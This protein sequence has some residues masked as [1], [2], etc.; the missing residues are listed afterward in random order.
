MKRTLM[1]VLF[2]VV[3]GVVF[4]QSK[5]A[6]T[7]K[8]YLAGM[9]CENCVAKVETALKAVDGVSSV[10]VSLKQSVANVTLASAIQTDALMKAV[11]D[12]GYTASLTKIDAKTKK[13]VQQHEGEHKKGEEKCD[14][15]CCEKEKKETV[16]S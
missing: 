8:L 16:K 5:K 4:G 7:V 9:H 2:L 6:S 13:E 14:G 3:A 15:D 11:S 1:L 10:K 12:A